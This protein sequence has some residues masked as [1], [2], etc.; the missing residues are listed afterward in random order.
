VLV[1]SDDVDWVSSELA[2]LDTI[3]IEEITGGFTT[4]GRPVE[5]GF[6]L[7]RAGFVSDELA[8]RAEAML[9]GPYERRFEVLI[10]DDWLDAWRDGFEPVSVGDFLVWPDW[11]SGVEIPTGRDVGQVVRFDPG[12]AWGTGGHQSTKLA[13]ELLQDVPPTTLA[14]ATVLDAGCGSGLLAVA[15]ALLGAVH[16]D[17]VD[18]DIT[19]PGV[20]DSNAARN[21]VGDRVHASNES[22][23]AISQRNAGRYDVVLAN[24]LAPVL[25]ELAPHLQIGLS[26]GGVL[27]LAGLIDTQVDQI[28]NAFAPLTV[29]REVHDGVWRGLLLR[30]P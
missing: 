30:R 26:T 5:A 17:A 22:V 21:G 3:G 24:I 9:D 2:E 14:H 25:I 27:I 1:P 20:T 13:L 11:K 18:I 6:T 4:R 29:V 10:G 7:L 8:A 23:E 15:A 19:A 28:R 12:R 16:V